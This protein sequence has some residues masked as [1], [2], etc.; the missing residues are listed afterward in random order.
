MK[1][2]KITTRQLSNLIREAFGE[3]PRNIAIADPEINTWS[4]AS[5]DVYKWSKLVPLGWDRTMGPRAR[6]LN[7]RGTKQGVLLFP[8]E[9]PAEDRI[10][11]FMK[12]YANLRPTW[13][14]INTE[15]GPAISMKFG[16]FRGM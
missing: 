5:P 7:S 11:S 15:E 16:I 8:G 4:D 14:L 1:T 2:V 13:D 12:K 3:Q 6:L 10:N 9:L